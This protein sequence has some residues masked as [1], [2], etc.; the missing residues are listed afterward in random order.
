MNTL[1]KTVTGQRR[2]YDL[3]PGPSA[4]ESSSELVGVEFNAPVDT[5]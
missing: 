3:N 2:G 1:S 5:I 4:P